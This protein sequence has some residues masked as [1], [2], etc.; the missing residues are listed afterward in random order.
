MKYVYDKM[1]KMPLCAISNEQYVD[2]LNGQAIT[3]KSTIEFI[4]KSLKNKEFQIVELDLNI[5]EIEEYIMPTYD[6][7]LVGYNYQINGVSNFLDKNKK[8]FTKMQRR[9]IISNLMK[10]KYKQ[11]RIWG[12]QSE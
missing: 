8:P 10:N 1:A 12:E 3:S 5:Y 11:T 7:C 6:C 9:Y 4:N 2:Y